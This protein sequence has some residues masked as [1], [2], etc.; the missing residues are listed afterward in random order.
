M[1][2]FS[3]HIKI[4]PSTTLTPLRHSHSML[5]NIDRDKTS[6]FKTKTK[7]NDNTNTNIPTIKGGDTLYSTPTD[8]PS[9]LNKRVV[10]SLLL[11]FLLT[12]LCFAG[13]PI[14]SLALVLPLVQAMR[15]FHSFLDSTK[16]LSSVGLG[17]GMISVLATCFTACYEPSMHPYVLPLS[18]IALVSQVLFTKT[19]ITPTADITSS[20]FSFMYITYFMSFWIRILDINAIDFTNLPKLKLGPLSLTSSSFLLW[21]TFA[22]I[23]SADIGGYVV[24]K[25]VDNMGL[26]VHPLSAWG[27]AGGKA[28]PRKTVEGVLGGVVFA[29]TTTLLGVWYLHPQAHAHTHTPAHAYVH[30]SSPSSSSSSQSLLALGVGFSLLYGTFLSL[31]SV[32]S[33]LS[34]SLWKRNAGVKDSG[35]LLPGHG[36]VLDRMDSYL[37]TGPGVCVWWALWA[38]VYSTISST[39]AVGPQSAP[40]GS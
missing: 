39:S 9:S 6:F 28:S 10:T 18:V 30:S 8:G 2:F 20:A 5:N 25:G 17:V 27:V 7:T 37:L 32:A 12:P 24:G 13:K 36:G 26:S 38:R 3:R 35:N 11:S 29:V 16:G 33:D 40:R 15:E 31:L 19:D 1:N 14:F 4:S 22:I 21:W 23:A 34:V